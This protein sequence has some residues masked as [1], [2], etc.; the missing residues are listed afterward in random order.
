MRSNYIRLGPFV[1][2]PTDPAEFPND[3]LFDYSSY[4]VLVVIDVQNL[5][6]PLQYLVTV[7][8]S[9]YEF[10]FGIVNL[11]LKGA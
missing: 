10:G 5:V 4:G 2:I 9:L 1:V 7:S 8:D 3:R 11:T 6:K